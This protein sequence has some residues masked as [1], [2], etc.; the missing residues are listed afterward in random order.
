MKR[1]ILRTLA[2]RLA[3]LSDADV[4]SRT[5][6]SERAEHL[7]NVNTEIA[8]LRQQQAISEAGLSSQTERLQKANTEIATLR[9]KQAISQADLSSQAERLRKANAEIAALKRDFEDH[10]L[11]RAKDHVRAAMSNVEPQFLPL[12]EQCAPYTMTSPERLYALYK[13]VIY[14]VANNIAGD[15]VECGVWRGGSMRMAA[16]AL[17]S[18]G[19]TGRKLFLYDTFEGMTAPDPERDIDLWGG[20]AARDYAQEQLAGRKWAYSPIEEVRANIASTGYPME[21]VEFVK[22]PVEET[23]PGTLP[24]RI[25]ILRLDTDWHQ[26]TMHEMEHLYP[27]LSGGGVLAV[28]DY[29][30]YRGA[31][32]AV[33][34]YLNRQDRKPL[35]HRTDYSCVFA[36]KP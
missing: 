8:T 34:E 25:S 23:L 18:L 7:Q 11:G 31:K 2:A 33:D 21:R 22:G 27:R 24:E 35:L 17:L 14:I 29:G 19:E 1:I 28:D 32:Q 13:A 12:Y 26:S 16:L 5:S 3:K 30:H 15:I 20:N 36:I 9:Q 10:Q 4:V 6:L